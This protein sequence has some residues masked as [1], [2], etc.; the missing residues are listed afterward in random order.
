MVVIVDPFLVSA[1]LNIYVRAISFL[2]TAY[3]RLYMTI[4]CRGRCWQQQPMFYD[5]PA[6]EYIYA[7][8]EIFPSNNTNDINEYLICCWICVKASPQ[9]LFTV[10]DFI[11]L[12][13]LQVL[14][15]LK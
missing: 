12:Y 11:M 10:L 14:T 8:I 15:Q 1:Q 13:T 4:P 5:Y 7:A 2:F 3:F 9:Q 6:H